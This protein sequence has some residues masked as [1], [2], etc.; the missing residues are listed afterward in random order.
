MALAD[1]AFDQLTALAGPIGARRGLS[2]RNGSMRSRRSIYRIAV[3]LRSRAG[4]RAW[5]TSPCRPSSS[6]L[7]LRQRH[8]QSPE[9]SCNSSAGCSASRVSTLPSAGQPLADATG[10][11]TSLFATHGFLNVEI[12]SEAARAGNR[13][14]ASATTPN[15]AES[16]AVA[17]RPRRARAGVES[18]F[19]FRAWSHVAARLALGDGGSSDV[20]N[21]ELVLVWRERARQSCLTPRQCMRP[22]RSSSSSRTS[23]PCWKPWPRIPQATIASSISSTRADR[24][25]LLYAWNATELEHD[26]SA[27]LHAAFER[28]AAARHRMPSRSRSRT[29]RSR[30]AV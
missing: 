7:R 30:S 14:A 28:Q 10:D 21:A 6:S 13:R 8:L 26:R 1:D 4:R 3:A 18:E 5:S 15:A 20:D 23:A 27:L 12:E 16:Q 25:K 9:R 17:A 2:G 11:F 19:D 29:E 22:R 24:R